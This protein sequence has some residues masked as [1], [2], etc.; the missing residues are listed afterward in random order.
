MVGWFIFI[1][2]YYSWGGNFPS[3]II[4]W[5]AYIAVAMAANILGYALGWC[6]HWLGQWWP[7]SKF[8][9][10]KIV[11]QSIVFT[12]G[13]F[14]YGKLTAQ[15]LL[16]LISD[17]NY[18]QLPSINYNEMFVRYA[19]I[20]FA[21]VLIY[22]LTHYLLFSY[23]RFIQR[24]ITAIE[25]QKEKTVLQ[26]E[27]LQKQLSPHYLFNSLN[28]ISNLIETSA[29]KT[30]EYIRKLVK[31]YQYILQMSNRELVS[32]NDELKMIK[33]YQY[34]LY[35]RFG[36]A[37]K[38]EYQIADDQANFKLPPLS[39]QTL[40]ENAVKHNIAVANAPLT[41][42]IIAKNKKLWVKNNITRSP[43]KVSSTKIGLNNLKRRYLLLDYG[44]LKIKKDSHF[45]IE[46]PLI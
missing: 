6:N 3:V 43:E 5:P 44:H 27:M 8:P 12:V 23:H 19:I 37:I 30:E 38:W 7:W 10:I 17:H 13:G 24:K 25:T 26:F 11:F 2:L 32:L 31:T 42:S 18:R 15:W 40:T 36:E 21:I 39:L 20:L 46:L 4:H 9:H 29:Q 41:I 22:T 14:Y 45:T 34:Q 16:K 35:T 33:A 1:Y 28:T